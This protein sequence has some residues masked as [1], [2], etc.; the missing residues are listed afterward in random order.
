MPPVISC[1]VI[2]LTISLHTHPP[3]GP[4][5]RYLGGPLSR[6][7][8]RV[9]TAVLQ[10]VVFGG[11]QRHAQG[12]LGEIIP[13]TTL[14]VLFT[15]R[16]QL[17]VPGLEYPGP[18]WLTG[19]LAGPAARTYAGLRKASM[20]ERFEQKPA[21][22]PRH[23]GHPRHRDA[24]RR[25]ARQIA[26]HHARQTAATYSNALRHGAQPQ[27]FHS[28]DYRNPSVLRPGALLLIGAGD[29]AADIG[30]SWHRRTER[31]SSA[32]TRHPPG[33]YRLEAGRMAFPQ[34]RSSW[35]H[36]LTEKTPSGDGTC[37]R[38]SGKATATC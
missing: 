7:R 8:N 3:L 10:K 12:V 1:G 31:S 37:R 19:R 33:R 21:G 4:G 14:R 24:A 2:S 18:S 6:A 35:T 11:Q 23:P 13:G 34:L 27:Q 28:S 38:R 36:L 16:Q 22:H 25:L 5:I 9:L 15:D 20:V 30:P 17:T 29:S 26:E 32:T